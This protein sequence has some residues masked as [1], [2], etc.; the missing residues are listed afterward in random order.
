MN[1]HLELDLHVRVLFINKILQLSFQADVYSNLQDVNGPL[2]IYL[3]V[4][5]HLKSQP[6]IPGDDE[7][8]MPLT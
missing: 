1:R 6:H 4:F 2:V 8:I 3:H 5:Q 7:L